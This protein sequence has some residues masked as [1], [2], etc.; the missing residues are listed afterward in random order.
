MF[1]PLKTLFWLAAASAGVYSAAA[2]SLL[3]PQG[4]S[5]GP[6]GYQVPEIGYF[7]GG[8]IGGPKNLSEEFRW[9]TPELYYS[10]DR[11]FLDYFGSN[12]VFAIE[13]VIAIMNGVTNVSAYSAQ[14]TEFPLES[15]RYNYRAQAMSLIDLKSVALNFLVEEMGLAEPDRWTWC[16]RSRE[17]QP[18][19]Q[20]PFMIY[21][22][23]KRNFDPVTWEPTS[24]V[25]GN[26]YSYVIRERCTGDNP[27][28]DAVE[29]LV[30]PLGVHYSAVASGG[31]DYGVFYTGLTRDDV[32]GLRYMWRTN[33]LNVEKVSSGSVLSKTN[34][35]T[36]QLLVSSNLSLLV[37]QSL[38]NSPDG[39]SA[40]Y[41]D[42][43]ILEST[44]IF[45][46]VVTTNRL[47]YFT[48]APYSPAGVAK[49]ATN[50]TY[51]T[52]AAIWYRHAF[53]NVITN[54]Y[55]TNGWMTILQTNISTTAC[56]PFAPAGAIC[57]NITQKTIFTN[58][59]NGDYFLLTTNSG[60]GFFPISTQLVRVLIETN[61]PVAATNAQEATNIFNQEY[62]ESYVTY[63][64][65]HVLV[66]YPVPCEND[67]VALRQ[68][69]DRIQFIRRDYD[70][71]LERYFHPVTNSYVLYAVTNNQIIPEHFHR[72]V[73]RPDFVFSA[74]ERQAGNAWFGWGFRQ[75]PHYFTPTNAADPNPDKVLGPGTLEAP[76]FIEFNKVGPLLVN[77]YN[78]F[79]PNSGLTEAAATTNFIW[80]SFD[81]TTNA[82]IVY[83][84]GTSIAD[85]EN[86][87]LIQ[88]QPWV[89]M[90]NRLA[91][92]SAILPWEELALPTGGLQQPYPQPPAGLPVEYPVRAW[93][94]VN[95]GQFPYAWSLAPGSPG[96]PPGLF[97][98]PDPSDS[99]RCVLAGT[100]TMVGTF[101]FVVRLTDAG[102]RS[103][104]RAY[105]ITIEP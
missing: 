86:Q 68:G 97:L 64:T 37:S 105:S 62:S 14:L 4:A 32:G 10:F 58:F 67:S 20:C 52:N 23:I 70:S 40:L 102:S 28:A 5:D 18:N 85:L 65:N 51:E 61:T 101:D 98:A 34:F 60:C 93:F 36:P 56:R 96:L 30:D 7:I 49:L 11:N 90:T 71:L 33:N 74:E 42:L 72:V 6:D 73:T 83:P 66:V 47:I 95:G 45:T 38:T 81:G 100:P 35:A 82:P 27:L 3:G 78:P 92:T 24:Y 13:Q 87:V 89:E 103:V 17:T 84:Q 46:N 43:I 19:L 76:L 69:M 15:M 29:F 57:T 50:I 75:A 99:S 26:L 59:V 9:N 48:N 104:D 55:Y 63:F 91:Q 22:V 8:D 31:I 39:L 54:T 77:V 94:A 2:F 79:L 12:G 80:G 16:L 1:R 44:P 88:V 21:G 41:P 53:G 25:N